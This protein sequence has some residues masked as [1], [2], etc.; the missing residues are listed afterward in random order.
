MIIFTYYIYIYILFFQAVL[1]E[2][3]RRRLEG[4]TTCKDPRLVDMED[5]K[6]ISQTSPKLTAN[7]LKPYHD[8]IPTK[9]S[10][11]QHQL[12]RPLR[13]SRSGLLEPIT[14]RS[15]N[16]SETSLDNSKNH[17]NDSHTNNN[18]EDYDVIL[19]LMS[20]SCNEVLNHVKESWRRKAELTNKDME[21]QLM[22]L[23]E[24]LVVKNQ[25]INEMNQLLSNQVGV[26]IHYSQTRK[27]I[28]YNLKHSL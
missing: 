8:T 1:A 11:Q 18:T 14:T 6:P 28:S 16:L 15:T 13:S 9:F 19:K 7:G 10:F 27:F 12:S 20:S 5:C 22:S 4:Q 25:S 17:E 21:M 3:G 2:Y 26:Q 24:E 23:K